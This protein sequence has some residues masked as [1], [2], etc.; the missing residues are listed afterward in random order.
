MKK[1]LLVISANT[2]WSML[3]FRKNL[4]KAL[5]DAGYRVVVLVPADP[6]EKEL[7][8]IG[9]E[10]I[11]ININRRGISPIDD[12]RLL[13]QYIK[14]MSELRPSAFIGYTIKPNIYGSLAGLVIGLPAISNVTGLGTAFKAR[15]ALQFVVSTMYRLAFRGARHVFFLNRD[16]CRLFID[17]S[18]VRQDQITVL[19][20]EGVDLKWFH[21]IPREGTKM[22]TFLLASRLIWEKGIREYAAAAKSLRERGYEFRFNL[23]G[24]LDESDPS[25]ISGE[26]VKKLEDE[27]AITYLGGSADVRQH[28]ANCDCLVLPSWY[29]EGIPRIL[30]EAAAMA[31]PLITTDTPG[32]REVV[33]DGETGYLCAPRSARSLES[34]MLKVAE[35]SEEGRLEMGRRG[36]AKAE[37]NFDEQIVIHAY[38]SA[39]KSLIPA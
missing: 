39:I 24:F 6:L 22:F 34:A 15:G 14:I 20:G 12:L 17:R 16:D 1:P 37:R 35:L 26:D 7:H 33:A 30:M 28:I 29:P 27:G 19:P 18:L 32:C 23:L 5:I 11:S 38:L 2:A 10:T 9:I 4:L 8:K 36:R 3:N 31:K 21:P 25:A 13:F